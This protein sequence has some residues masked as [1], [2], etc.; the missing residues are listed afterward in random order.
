MVVQVM[1]GTRYGVISSKK[2]HI[3]VARV[4]GPKSRA[5]KFSRTFA[6]DDPAF[7]VRSL[8]LYMLHLAAQ[9]PWLDPALRPITSREGSGCRRAR[10][11]CTLRLWQQPLQAHHLRQVTTQDS[12]SSAS[13]LFLLHSMS[14]LVMWHL[15]KNFDKITLFQPVSVGHCKCQL[16]CVTGIKLRPFCLQG[17]GMSCCLPCSLPLHTHDDVS[18]LPRCRGAFGYSKCQTLFVH[19]EK[20]HQCACLAG[21]WLRLLE[22]CRE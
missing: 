6:C 20:E 18:W 10:L 3:F 17:M 11:L 21:R 16:A 15:A 14:S 4:G 22:A 5:V 1:E 12:P 19:K 13:W 7:P 8:Y 9:E 2:W